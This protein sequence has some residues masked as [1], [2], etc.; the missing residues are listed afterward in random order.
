MAIQY[1][2]SFGKKMHIFT[3]DFNDEMLHVKVLSN[4]F[5][6]HHRTVFFVSGCSVRERTADTR[7]GGAACRK[8]AVHLPRHVSPVFLY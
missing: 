5:V 7:A 3:L 8:P 6:S 2:L 4:R 1:P